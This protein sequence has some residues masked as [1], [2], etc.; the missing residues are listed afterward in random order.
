ME[1]NEQKR[2]ER[3]RALHL[4]IWI[5]GFAATTAFLIINWWLTPADEWGWTEWII[6][7]FVFFGVWVIIHYIF[8]RRQFKN[9]QD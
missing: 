6:P 4:R 3:R 7:F 2:E 8:L 5:S 1:Q 9:L